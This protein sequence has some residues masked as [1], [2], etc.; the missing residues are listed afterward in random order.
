MR[1]DEIGAALIP[2]SR[3]VIA[4]NCGAHP[5]IPISA[6]FFVIVL[7]MTTES[8]VVSVIDDVK[9]TDQGGSNERID[10]RPVAA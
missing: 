4:D 8:L 6:A 9:P 5:M 2:P 1:L 3:G 10:V 7:P